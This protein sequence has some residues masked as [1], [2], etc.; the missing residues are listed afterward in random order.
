MKTVLHVL[1]KVMGFE[2]KLQN[3]YLRD[4]KMSLFCLLSVV[5]QPR[6]MQ[7]QNFTC[8]VVEIEMRAEFEHRYGP[9]KGVGSRRVESRQGANENHFFKLAK[10]D[11][12]IFGCFL[13]YYKSKVSTKS[14]RR[15]RTCV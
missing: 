1:I 9:S 12:M 2:Q 14:F 6:K 7:S 3:N 11:T 5:S 10:L 8:G 4:L 15:R 13:R